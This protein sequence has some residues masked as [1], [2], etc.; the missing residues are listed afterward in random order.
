MTFPKQ[1]S[2]KCLQV[3]LTCGLAFG[4]LACASQTPYQAAEGKGEPGY[5]E[6]I[7]TKDR[8]RIIFT[9]NSITDKETVRDYAM[10]RA[11]EVTMEHGFDWFETVDRETDK[12]TRTTTT[13][14][15]VGPSFQTTY[16]TAQSCDALGNCDTAVYSS[17]S[18]VYTGAGVSTTTSRDSY[19]VTLEIRMGMD[20]KPDTANA[21]DAKSVAQAVRSRIRSAQKD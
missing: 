14:G 11:A 3:G 1:F 19:A 6:T 16:Y 18:P 7:V 4:L 5:Y 9:G 21:Y 2:R 17:S 13:G 10:L 15:T 20:P 12:K 8:Y